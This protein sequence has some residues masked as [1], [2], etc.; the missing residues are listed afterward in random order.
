[1]KFGSIGNKQLHPFIVVKRLKASFDNKTKRKISWPNRLK[2]SMKAKS[3]LSVAIIVVLLVSVFAFISQQTPGKPIEPTNT[4]SPTAPPTAAPQNISKPT[5]KPTQIPNVLT[6]IG[7]ALIQVFTPPKDPGFIETSKGMNSTIWRQVAAAAWQYFEP[8]IGVDENTS[9]PKSGIGSPYFT[10]WDLGVYIQAVMDANATGL[11]GYNGTW[12]SS[13]RLEKIVNWLETREL[14]ATTH[15][16]YWF[17]QSSNGSD[18]HEMSDLST[19]IVDGADIGRLLV[20][21]NNLRIFNASLAP[22]INNIVLY[23]QLYN[24]S[25]FQTLVPSVL[26]DSKISTSIYSYYVYS[27]FASFWPAQLSTAPNMILNNILTSGNVTTNNVT[28]PISSILGDPLLCSVFDLSNN[29]SK[30]M[31]LMHQVYLAHEAYYNATGVYRA[32]SEG[33]SLDYHW[34]YEWVV[35]GN[36]TWVILDENYQPFDIS[37]IIYT[38]VAM[39]FLAIY[40]T[41]YAYNMNVHLEKALPAPSNG[42]SEGVTEDSRQLAGTGSNTNG[43]ILSAAKYA[44]QNSP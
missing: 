38:K 13:A 24:R 42:F 29:S 26:A 1:M 25:D 28:L 12:G 22:R 21:L 5:S 40:N 37:P 30:L 43:L 39:G 10:D 6:G 14:N 16:P 36:R 17:Y 41:S 32:F 44:I 20:A 7:N 35:L 4:D 34:T 19:A 9:L 8:G 23:G 15:Y 33:A 18:Y 11:I 2:L 3:V 27:G 31:Y